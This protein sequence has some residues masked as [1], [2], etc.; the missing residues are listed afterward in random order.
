MITNPKQ[1]AETESNMKIY[2]LYGLIISLV[3]AGLLGSFLLLSGNFGELEIRILLSI[4]AFAM[5]SIIGLCCNAIIG[6]KYTTFGM[7]GVGVTLIGLSYALITTWITPNSASFLQFRF[8]LLLIALCFAHCSLM[9]LLKIHSS[10]GALI[11]S[12]SII[13]S[14]I[15]CS[16]LVIFITSLEANEEIFKFLSV[17]SIVCVVSTII[18]PIMA[19]IE[20][21]TP[22]RQS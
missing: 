16:I 2:F 5:Y 21:G 13:S 6:G 8:S 18:A 22:T 12:I 14:I 17:T 20:K 1:K 10:F 9:F 4:S 19:F 15:V 11:R 3:I 7:V